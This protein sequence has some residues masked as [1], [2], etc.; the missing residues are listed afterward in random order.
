MNKKNILK[1]FS[2][3][4]LGVLMF[5]SVFATIVPTTIS[6]VSN[7][8]IVI[9]LDNTCKTYGD[10]ITV[11]VDDE[12][13]IPDENIRVTAIVA[14]TCSSSI[15]DNGVCTDVVEMISFEITQKCDNSDNS[16]CAGYLRTL[17]ILSGDTKKLYSEVALKL[18]GVQTDSDNNVRNAKL[19]IIDPR[20]SNDCDILIC[21]DGADAYGTGNYNGNGCQI[22]KCPE[23]ACDIPVCTN[24]N[25][26]LPTGNYNS[27]GCEIYS[28]PDLACSMPI[29]EDGEGESTGN[30]DGRGC[31]IYKCP[32]LACDIPVCDDAFTYATGNYNGQGC[33]I[34]SCQESKCAKEG[35]YTSG[36]VSPEY[37]FG[38]CEGLK[39]FNTYPEGFVGGGMLCYDSNK[40][41][42]LCTSK[43]TKNE[44]WYYPNGISLKNGECGTSVGC[45]LVEFEDG[46]YGFDEYITVGVG[47]KFSIKYENIKVSEINAIKCNTADESISCTNDVESIILEITPKCDN[48]DGSVCALYLRELEIVAGETVKLSSEV[49]LELVGIDSVSLSST[50]SVVNVAKLRIVNQNAYNVIGAVSTSTQLNSQEGGVRVSSVAGVIS[51]DTETG[52]PSDVE[53]K[54]NGCIVNSNC[55]SYGIRLK[56]GE[57]TYCEIDGTLKE[58]KAIDKVCE[59]NYECLSNSCSNGK[60]VDFA[61]QLEETQGVLNK[62]VAWINSVFGGFN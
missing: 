43:G 8:C 21:A 25:D 32:E 22:Y 44:G 50:K 24:D 51:E 15:S 14:Q 40:G 27:N 55:V 31:L 1:L 58:Q 16:V 34:Y 45:D 48:S 26:A 23:F 29:C 36:A 18:V 19:E 57:S 39:S 10:H 35:E 9:E 54:C 7:E 4:V 13:S 11:S 30:Y 37:Q 38:C 6:T 28:C 2:F 33:M 12:F 49:V 41:T 46:C 17:E 3:L 60:C 42:P 59:N 5:G 61:Q 53:S 20:A 56:N 62:I 52:N 47:D